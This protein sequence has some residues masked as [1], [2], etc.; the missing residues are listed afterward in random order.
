MR[1]NNTFIVKCYTKK[2]LRNIYG[3][4][5][6]TFNKWLNKLYNS[7]TIKLVKSQKKMFTPSEVNIIIKA[8]GLP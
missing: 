8:I 6:G 4:S 1:N 2:E 3:V 5:K 7:D